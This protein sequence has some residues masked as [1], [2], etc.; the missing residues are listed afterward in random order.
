MNFFVY[1]NAENKLR[2]EEYSILLVKEFGDL[3]DIQRNKCKEDKTG[4][5]RLR[6]YKELTYI[7][8]TL[9]FKSPYFQYL[10]KERHEAA[11]EDSGLK[12]SDLK[13]EVF[14]AAYHKYQE[15]QSADP[16]L[17]LIK[18]AYKTLHKMQVFLDNIDFAED[19]DADGRP[20][21]KPKDVIADIKSIA[22]VRRELKE[23]EAT[24]KK[25][26]S[27]AGTKVRGDVALGFKDA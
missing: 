24:H 26:L 3:W 5:L 4:K 21:Y 17:S 12:E 27:E 25:D 23:L 9:D 1:D 11:L 7:Y 13:D 8:L 20:L 22:D 15:L 16:I 2:I 10:E 19:V 18:T 14:L 6:A